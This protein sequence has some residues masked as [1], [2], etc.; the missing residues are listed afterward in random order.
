MVLN[1]TSAG[2]SA[3]YGL[4]FFSLACYCFLDLHIVS[5]IRYQFYIYQRRGL[6]FDVSDL[7]FRHLMISSVLDQ[8]C[9]LFSFQGMNLSADLQ[10]TGRSDRLSINMKLIE[11][12]W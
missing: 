1:R 11:W 8:I 9:L 5:L 3:A 10:P 12:R 2:E 4:L 7:I 6:M